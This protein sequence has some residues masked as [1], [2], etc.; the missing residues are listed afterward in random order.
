VRTER[1]KYIR[2][3]ESNPPREQL[4]DLT[5]DPHEEK[6]LAHDLANAKTLATLRA[7]CNEYRKSLP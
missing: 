1:W 7:R 5:A 6:D 4:F 2:Y 3:T